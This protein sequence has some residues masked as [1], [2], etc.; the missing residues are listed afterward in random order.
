MSQTAAA[1]AATFSSPAVINALLLLA[2]ALFYF[3]VLATLF[4]ARHR[5]GIGAFF[6]AL[7]VMH[8]LET[9]LA[10]VVYVALPF[11]IV[12]SPGS[13][14]LFTGKLMLLLL[15]YIR[16]DAVVVRQPI[17]GLL[18]GNLLLFAL[19][20]LTRRHGAESV[21][22]NRHADFAFLDEMGA[23]MVWG[24][25]ILF[26]DCILM[27][28]LYERSRTFL[29]GRRLLLRLALTGALILSFDQIAFYGG[30]RYLTGAP[31]AVLFG[32]WISKMA[33][34]A[35]YAVLG[36]A[37]LR[38][39]ELPRKA[40]RPPRIIDVFDLLTYR[41]RYEDLLAR[42]GRDALTGAL[43]R[44]RL[45]HMGRKRVEEATLAGRPLSLLIIDIDHFKSFNDRFGHAA[46]DVVLQRIVRIISAAMRPSDAVFRFGGE[47]FVVIADELAR[48]AAL[49]LGERIRR[50]VASH[51]EADVPLVTVSIGL[52]TCA[53]D[54]SDYEALFDCA[55]RRLY[56]AKSAGRNCVIG[57]T[58]TDAGA[59]KLAW[60]G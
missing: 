48:A 9:Y 25:L 2:D 20:F 27:I 39:V 1:L 21:L 50:D 51:M 36:A 14:V 57:E 26:V 19:A 22:A 38:R 16:E 56:L 37:Y 11:G 18:I 31:L 58:G 41:E 33:A 29:G 24:T 13:T 17:Y 59:P 15:V 44:G 7:G 40:K 35:I 28:L 55:D 6:C 34:V 42:S 10:S 32:G 47:E 45:E 49:A 43:D 3:A 52:A 30:L 12:A 5:I 54:A 46:G 4:R 53:E 8:F 23:L 60:A